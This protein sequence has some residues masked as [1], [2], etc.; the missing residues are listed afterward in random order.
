VSVIIAEIMLILVTVVL[1]AILAVM[2]SG[3]MRAPQAPPLGYNF[4][5]FS[6]G[7]GATTAPAHGNVPVGVG[8]T[9]YTYSFMLAF[10][11]RGMVLGDLQFQVQSPTDAVVQANGL[12]LSVEGLSQNVVAVYYFSNA[13]WAAGPGVAGPATDQALSTENSLVVASPVSLGGDTLVIFGET[14]YSGEVTTGFP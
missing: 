13:T 2:A 12:T 14:A 5:I 1:A 7:S 3:L 4:A 10:T 8:A 6:S 11:S 9:V